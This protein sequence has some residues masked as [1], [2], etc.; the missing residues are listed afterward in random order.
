M[1]I[2]EQPKREW[3]IAREGYGVQLQIYWKPVQAWVF[4]RLSPADIQD[5]ISELRAIVGG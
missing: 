2:E 1:D 4:V 5:L 3:G